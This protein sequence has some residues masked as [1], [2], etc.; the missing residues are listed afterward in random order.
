[1]KTLIIL[2]HGKAELR[3]PDLDDYDRAL[4]ER[5]RRNSLDIGRFICT[6]SG[7]PDLILTSSAKRAFETAQLA[8]EGIGY[9]QKA[10][11]SDD[12]LYFAS[13][14]WMLHVLSSVPDVVK[15]CVLVGHNPGLTDLINYFGLRLDNLPTASA[16]CFEFDSDSWK[17]ISRANAR[18]RWF[19]PA[20]K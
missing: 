8:A 9:E 3:R 12:E 15:S 19:Q 4:I 10:I 1:M 17:D 2:R 11:R 18:F 5:G 20:D 7:V 6:K 14:R 16:V 13:V